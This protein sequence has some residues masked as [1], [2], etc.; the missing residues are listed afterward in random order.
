[1]REGVGWG[2]NMFWLGG[3]GLSTWIRGGLGGRCPPFLFVF[4]PFWR[5]YRMNR[6][7][8]MEQDRIETELVCV[9]GSI[10]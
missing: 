8:N 2:V 4:F 6:G 10:M 9:L 5:E 1:M 3:W 7:M